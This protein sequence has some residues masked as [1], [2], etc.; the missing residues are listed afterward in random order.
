MILKIG[1]RKSPLARLQAYQV[2]DALQSKH[3]QLKVEYFFKES[4]G[5]KNLT[6]PLWKMPERGV[7]TED[8]VQ[9][10]HQEKVDLVVHSW[11]DL[12]TEERPG[13]TIF[14]CPPRAD[15]RDLFLFRKSSLGKSDLKILT[16][17]P[18]REFSAKKFLRS[19]LPFS[20]NELEFQAVRG[21]VNTRIR[22]LVEGQ[23]D[24]LFLAKAALDRLLAETREEF[25]ST[26][27]EIREFLHDLQWCVLPLSYFPTAAA[28]GALAIEG[29]SK[30]EDLRELL[31]PIL[32]LQSRK[33][34][35]EERNLFRSY[36][37][38]C[39]QKIGLSFATHPRLGQIQYF[40]GTSEKSGE[41]H[42]VKAEK[43]PPPPKGKLWPLEPSPA[44]FQRQS[45]EVAHPNTDL[46]VA[47]AEALPQ[48]KMGDEIIWG[49]GVETWHRL[50]K[51]GVWVHGCQEGLGEEPP[52]IDALVGRTPNFTKLSHDQS[53]N[54]AIFPILA[55]YRLV[56][57]AFDLPEADSYFWMSETS[58]L[59]A[60]E[61][62]PELKNREHA[63]GPGYT[64]AALEKVLGK[65]V[66]VYM[67]YRHWKDG[68]P[69]RK[70]E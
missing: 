1:A 39:H 57:R 23:G 2:G 14:G 63:C 56:P 40:L 4:L 12:P 16:S 5:D 28:Q 29:L 54:T 53:E 49:A 37:G 6:D 19:L 70:E 9:D 44:F 38:G 7:F 34:V 26:Q 45:L 60:L 32:C 24:G 3:P 11:K 68:N 65:P 59:R 50:T 10:L 25:R 8:F 55:T 43:S 20:V 33:N 66:S 17:S 64:A 67:N 27:I 35:E 51:R 21:N 62:Y 22:K 58:F 30:R 31:Q 13:L 18:R 36:G 42:W 52:A 47:R 46:F 69:L 41:E 15:Q 61:L 48:W